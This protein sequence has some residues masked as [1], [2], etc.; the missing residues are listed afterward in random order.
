MTHARGQT[1]GQPWTP[2]SLAGELRA[3]G[4]KVIRKSNGWWAQCPCPEH[5]D[6]NPSLHFHAGE[7]VPLVLKCR[8]RCTQAA[9]LEAIGP[10]PGWTAQP[11]ALQLSDDP[12]Q[13]MCPAHHDEHHEAYASAMAKLSP[14]DWANLFTR[15]VHETQRQ[16]IRRVRLS[17]A[18]ART[19][20][21]VL[22][23][24]VSA[25][26]RAHE[27]ALIQLPARMGKVM[28]LVID[29]LVAITN[30]RLIVGDTRAVPYS[31]RWAGDRLGVD[32]RKVREALK[33][34]Q[35]H[36]IVIKVGEL[37]N[38]SEWPQGTPLYA[39]A[40][41]GPCP[42]CARDVEAGAVVAGLDAEDAS[43]SG[44]RQA[45]VE[46]RD[47]QPQVSAVGV[48]ELEDVADTWLAAPEGGA[49]GL[50]GPTVRGHAGEGYA[51][52]T[53]CLLWEGPSAIVKTVDDLWNP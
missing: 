27:E 44:D 4:L 25:N 30:A 33:R 2:E 31:S 43:A 15:I 3:R 50:A 47:E 29:D 17:P 38:G 26:E 5:D 32:D 35:K 40:V 41:R 20:C 14:A 46:P 28:K 36:K 8:S 22:L 23:R 7:N 48:A 45:V 52:E 42:R 10:P 19:G 39:L 16:R 12:A 11:Y 9:V 13:W 49:D 53:T 21:L 6:R 18:H 37:P 51:D 34:L 1:N 24:E